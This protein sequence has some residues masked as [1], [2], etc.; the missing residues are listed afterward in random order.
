VCDRAAVQNIRQLFPLTGAQLG[1]PATA[2]SLQQAFIAML[3]PSPNP[4][5]SAGA[6]HLQGG[7]DL[8]GG[9]SPDTEHDG[10]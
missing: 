8:T 4:S 7:G 9:Q 6:I 10:L 5:V 3:I 1:G 2:M